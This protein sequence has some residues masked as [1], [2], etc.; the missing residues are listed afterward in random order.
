[1][2]DSRLDAEVARDN[3]RLRDAFETLL[4]EIDGDPNTSI[5]TD[6]IRDSLGDG[7]DKIRPPWE[8]AGYDDK[9]P[10][11]EAKRAAEDEGNGDE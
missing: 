10:W 11:L 1:M 3:N 7:G 2:K 4:E 8:R 5:D 6:R 9:G